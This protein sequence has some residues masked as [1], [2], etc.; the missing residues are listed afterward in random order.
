MDPRFLGFFDESAFELGVTGVPESGWG[1]I[2][3]RLIRIQYKVM[4]GKHLN[5][6]LL[7]S[8]SQILHWDLTAGS[9]TSATCAAYFEDAREAIR[10]TPLRWIQMDNARIHNASLVDKIRSLKNCH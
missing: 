7:I 2:S 1:P 4:R 3:D 6:A 8:T 9:Y 10:C 5:F